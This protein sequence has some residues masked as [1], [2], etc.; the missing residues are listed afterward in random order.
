MQTH[1]GSRKTIFLL[2]GSAGVFHVSAQE[3]TIITTITI[4]IMIF[5]LEASLSRLTCWQDADIQ[6]GYFQE[7]EV[8]VYHSRTHSGQLGCRP[9]SEP[10]HIPGTNPSWNRLLGTLAQSRP[11]PIP[12]NDPKAI[13]SQPR[14]RCLPQ[15]S[16]SVQFGQK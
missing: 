1:G 9:F 12:G 16:F 11:G 10:L 13:H 7:G 5:T 14:H 8:V 2:S 6:E 4:A 3:A 15:V